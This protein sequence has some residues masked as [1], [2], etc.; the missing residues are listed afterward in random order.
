MRTASARS[1]YVHQALLPL[2]AILHGTHD[3]GRFNPTLVGFD[4]G[5][6]GEG[7]SVCQP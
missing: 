3:L 4:V 5:V 6:A 7:L 1:T 2:G